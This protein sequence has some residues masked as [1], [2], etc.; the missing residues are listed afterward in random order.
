LFLRL[1]LY[2]TVP[3][4]R[5]QRIIRN[6][7]FVRIYTLYLYTRIRDT[8]LPPYT[9]SKLLC[10][11]THSSCI[12]LRLIYMINL[13]PRN[14]CVRNTSNTKWK[15]SRTDVRGY[16]PV[17]KRHVLSNIYIYYNLVVFILRQT[18]LVEFRCSLGTVTRSCSSD[19]AP[20]RLH[21]YI[22][23]YKIQCWSSYQHFEKSYV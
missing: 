2:F 19:E 9:A 21:T 15:V 22:I 1:R 3:P 11:R 23:L 14:S 16:S 18:F 17:I 10:L 7:Y 4:F 12:H 20:P 5:C 8:Y 6:I 13:S